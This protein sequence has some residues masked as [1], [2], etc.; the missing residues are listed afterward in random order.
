[1][2][3]FDEHREILGVAERSLPHRDDEPLF[4]VAWHAR[5]FALMVALVKN[6]H[7]PWAAFQE[8]LAQRI[9]D[10]ETGAACLSNEETDLHYFDCWLEAA[11]AT[12]VEEGF[13]AG[14]EIDE[15]I[16]VIHRTVDA[17][18][19]RQISSAEAG[20]RPRPLTIDVPS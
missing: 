1:M 7:I 18:R 16:A 5:V 17:I 20:A 8:R 11:H 13:V 2:S 15:R 19:E 10:T 6:G 3:A 14:P 9:S 12:L 4:R